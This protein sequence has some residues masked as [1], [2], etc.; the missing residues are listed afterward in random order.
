MAKL[1]VHSGTPQACE[2]ILQMGANY[3]GR[4]DTNHLRIDDPSV[5]GTHATINVTENQIVVTDLN[6]TNGTFVNQ[7]R[8]TESLLQPGQWLRLGG[9]SILIETDSSIPPRTS[10]VSARVIRSAEQRSASDEG[11]AIIS[12]A[13]PAA[14][15]LRIS[16]SQATVGHASAVVAPPQIA[17]IEEHTEHPV[18][19]NV[20]LAQAP[21]GKTAC[22]FHRK[23]AGE[24]LCRTCNELFCTVCVSPKHAGGTTSF[25]CRKCGSICVPVK[26]N[27]VPPKEKEV[28]IVR[29]SDGVLL[30]RSV[31]FAFAAAI[32]SALIWTGLSWLF[33]FDIPYIFCMISAALCGYAV[34]IG[35]QDTPGPVFSS[36]AVVFCIIGSVLGKFGM[37]AVTHLTQQSNTSLATTGIGF[38]ISIYLAWKIGGGD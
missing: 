6:S 26:V 25:A 37:V 20:Q 4:A 11:T 34:K 15:G 30:G 33:G 12:P 36:I 7:S 23:S 18:A 27:F 14:L 28:K 5:S 10:P 24:W 3:L 1:V 8:I 17:A 22:K 9:V 13:R 2:F 19:S 29:Y 35:C 32:L 31:G 38:I 16:S 21:A